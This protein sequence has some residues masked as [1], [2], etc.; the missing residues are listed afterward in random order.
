MQK[1]ADMSV[2]RESTNANEQEENHVCEF[3]KMLGDLEELLKSSG[4]LSGD[5]LIQLNRMIMD[6]VHVAAEFFGDK[7]K[8]I[9]YKLHETSGR[10]NNYVHEWP[11]PVM[12]IGLAVGIICGLLLATKA[13]SKQP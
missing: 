9:M 2:A 5:D 12:G 10:T 6:R 7:K 3:K 1:A 8:S 13:S 11:W 4:S